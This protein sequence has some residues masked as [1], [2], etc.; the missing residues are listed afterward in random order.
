[1]AH[2]SDISGINQVGSGIGH[3]ITLIV[4][5]DPDSFIYLMISIILL[6]M[7][8]RKGQSGLNFLNCPGNIRLH[9]KCGIYKTIHQVI[10][11]N[12]KW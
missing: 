4:D 2:V 1:M 7:I 10:P 3:D 9:L 6:K 11:L 12:L 8:I 5:E